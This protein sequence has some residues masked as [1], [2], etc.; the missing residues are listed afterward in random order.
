MAD[1][2]VPPATTPTPKA[3]VPGPIYTEDAGTYQIAA[4]YIQ[5]LQRYR[6]D[7]NITNQ[8]GVL[9]KTVSASTPPT[10]NTVAPADVVL[11]KEAGLE[12]ALQLGAKVASR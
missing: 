9:S 11:I 7:V 10:G 3:E 8:A 4:Y 1:D 5:P 12:M 2:S 6:V